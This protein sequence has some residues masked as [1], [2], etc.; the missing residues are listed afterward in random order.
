MSTVDFVYRKSLSC[1]YFINIRFLCNI[2]EVNSILFDFLNMTQLNFITFIQSFDLI[3]ILKFKSNLALMKKKLNAHKDLC[4][5]TIFLCIQKFSPFD[6]SFL[7]REFVYLISV[8][9]IKKTYTNFSFD[10]LNLLSKRITMYY[11][12]LEYSMRIFNRRAKPE[13]FS[14]YCKIH[15]N[16]PRACER[17]T[18][19]WNN[20]I[21]KTLWCSYGSS[22]W[23]IPKA[24]YIINICKRWKK[25]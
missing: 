24:R 14:Q 25:C 17:Q 4:E 21:K 9:L 19:Q 18:R 16:E 1:M 12:R 7:K 6:L 10:T 15:W 11:V 5:H 22:D 3:W 20:K 2:P 8:L 13:F 23:Q